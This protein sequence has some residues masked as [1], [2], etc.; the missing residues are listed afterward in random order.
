MRFPVETTTMKNGEMTTIKGEEM[1]KKFEDENKT[2]ALQALQRAA[3]KHSEFGHENIGAN[4]VIE[5]GDEKPVPPLVDLGIFGNFWITKSKSIDDKV[6]MH[7]DEKDDILK[8]K[9]KPVFRKED[10]YDK[11]PELKQH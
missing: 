8:E 10:Y 1:T 4:E 2:A 7:A 5:N 11:Y 6:H 3:K 9:P